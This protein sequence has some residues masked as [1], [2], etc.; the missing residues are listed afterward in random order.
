MTHPQPHGGF[1]GIGRASPLRCGR[2]G[3][4]E[5]LVKLLAVL[6]GAILFSVVTTLHERRQPVTW[7]CG[8]FSATTMQ[9]VT[10]SEPGILGSVGPSRIGTLWEAR[11]GLDYQ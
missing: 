9:T 5:D 7:S 4:L 8:G 11:K 3:V 10:Q 2:G 1:T 6:A